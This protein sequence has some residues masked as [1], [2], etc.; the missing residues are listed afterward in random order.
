MSKGFKVGIALGGG[1]ARG[2][3]HIGV[4]KALK[5]HSI[6]IDLI[7]GTSMGAIVGAT[8]CLNP[9]VDALENKLLRT[10]DRPQIKKLESFFA[11]TSEENHQNFIIQNLLSKI[12][13]LCLW[14]LRAAKKWVVRTEPI[15][16]VLEEL[17]DDK[18]FSDLAIPFTSI[19]VDLNTASEVAIKTGRILDAILASSSIPGIFAPVK[20][21]NHLLADG[22]VLSS[23]PARQARIQGADFVIGID[24]NTSFPKKEL[25]TGLDVMFQ[26]DQI[27]TSYLNK[28]DLTYCDCVI[29][30]NIVNV[31]WSEFSRGPFCIQQGELAALKNIAGIK[32]ALT[33]KKRFYHL[34]RLFKRK[35]PSLLF[36]PLEKATHKVGGGK[37]IDIDA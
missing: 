31:D 7:T 11:I 15:V 30:P 37:N 29:K 34:R 20:F 32:S 27:K 22:G 2:F 24:I 3:A 4:I 36:T 14:N 17:F 1:G 19:A 25:R 28:L 12:K 21:G 26:A 13:D 5:A 18:K 8:Y 16:K 9:D 6:P 10:I 35:N 23:V 33:N